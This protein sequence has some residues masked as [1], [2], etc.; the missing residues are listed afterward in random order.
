[1]TS[2]AISDTLDKNRVILL[3]TAV[4]MQHIIQ[5]YDVHYTLI[6]NSNKEIFV[7]VRVEIYLQ[8]R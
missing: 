8:F 1:V 5:L 6:F 4:G 2:A 7:K 3:Q